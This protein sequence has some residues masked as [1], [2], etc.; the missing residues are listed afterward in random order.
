MQ[1]LAGHEGEQQES[2]SGPDPD[3]NKTTLHK[4]NK[5]RIGEKAKGTATFSACHRSKS[6]SHSFC[7]FQ[8]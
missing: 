1:H 4:K 3:P 2:S 8:I 6:S 5:H 7:E